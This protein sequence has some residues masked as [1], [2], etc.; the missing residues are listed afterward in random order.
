MPKTLFVGGLNPSTQARELGEAFQRFGII[1]R[2]DILAP[3]NNDRHPHAFIEFRHGAN[4]DEA[5]RNLHHTSFKGHPLKISWAHNP[6]A[7]F[8]PPASDKNRLPT[9]NHN[10]HDRSR[11][12]IPREQNLHPRDGRRNAPSPNSQHNYSY[13]SRRRADCYRPSDYRGYYGRREYSDNEPQERRGAWKSSSWNRAYASP[14]DSR[15]FR[16]KMTSSSSGDTKGFD[17][18]EARSR[19]KGQQSEREEPYFQARPAKYQFEDS[20][21]ERDHEHGYRPYTSHYHRHQRFLDA[22][23]DRRKRMRRTTASFPS[24]RLPSQFGSRVVS[25]NGG[26]ERRKYERNTWGRPVGSVSSSYSQSTQPPVRQYRDRSSNRDRVQSTPSP[27]HRSRSRSPSSPYSRS[28]SRSM[29]PRTPVILERRNSAGSPRSYRV[30]ASPRTPYTPRSARSRAS[31]TDYAR[32]P[33]GPPPALEGD[34]DNDEP[35][36][37]KEVVR[38][39]SLEGDYRDGY[40]V[41]E[42]E[43]RTPE[44]DV[45]VQMESSP[46]GIEAK[47]DTGGK[48]GDKVGAEAEARD[49]AEPGIEA[50]AGNENESQPR[51]DALA[52]VEVED[53]TGADGTRTQAVSRDTVELEVGKFGF[54]VTEEATDAEARAEAEDTDEAVDSAEPG[55]VAETGAQ[56]TARAEIEIESGT[57]PTVKND[58]ETEDTSSLAS[59]PPEFPAE[60]GESGSFSTS[61]SLPAFGPPNQ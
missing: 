44:A 17:Y 51:L 48:T 6:P 39:A 11:S 47:N 54:V 26:F 57:E 29:S 20:G 12:P 34:Y 41:D 40:P 35:S 8:G 52:V 22:D 3:R 28:R 56:A 16:S 21:Y 33:P 23:E 45:E 25:H 38:P 5:L 49:A 10:R 18:R 13:P 24:N 55:I 4:A 9:T 42:Y 1:E 43:E 50:E 53:A 30:T 46:E 36:S 58:V 14:R 19:D 59:T 27:S 31:G 2:C 61:S 7:F 60:E 32:T 37:D 15:D